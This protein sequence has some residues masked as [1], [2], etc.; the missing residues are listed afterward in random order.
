MLMSP[1]G[2]LG[3]SIL[4]AQLILT[5]VL[6]VILAKN[7]GFLL[8]LSINLTKL[9]QK[10]LAGALLMVLMVTGILFQLIRSTALHG[11]IANACS[12]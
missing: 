7:L 1:N 9:K 4:I 2:V 6:P 3:M 10:D 5:L 11:V 8:I 12:K